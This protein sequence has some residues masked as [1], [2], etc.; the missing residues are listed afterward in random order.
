[1]Q[2]EA[3]YGSFLSWSTVLGTLDAPSEHPPTLLLVRGVGQMKTTLPRLLAGRFLAV[4]SF[5]SIG[6]T[7]QIWKA[8]MLWGSSF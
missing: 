4:N 5:L 1:M 7:H 2:Q 6:F 8:G 3:S